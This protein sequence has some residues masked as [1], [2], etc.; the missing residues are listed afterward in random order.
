MSH[1]VMEQALVEELRLEPTNSLELKSMRGRNMTILGASPDHEG[2]AESVG[3]SRAS[4]SDDLY[5]GDTI[6]ASRQKIKYRIILATLYWSYFSYGLN[7]GTT[8]PL[9][10]VY[11]RDFKV[12]TPYSMNNHLNN[13]ISLDWI[14]DSLY[15]LYLELR[16]E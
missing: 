8:G 1:T 9:L 11:Q 4:R 5:E 6:S 14:Y 7:D 13:F 16:C 3:G 10:P 15:D 2:V 12:M